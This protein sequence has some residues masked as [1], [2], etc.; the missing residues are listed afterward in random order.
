MNY[1]SKLDRIFSEYIRR[2]DSDPTTGYG[3][4]ISCGKVVHW[5][6]AD[7]GHY[8]NRKHMSLRYDER[9]VHLQC[10]SCNRYD[11]GNMLGYTK[12]LQKKYGERV[13][14][15]LQVKK[16]N[17]SKLGPY[18]FELL[19]KQYQKKLNE[20]KSKNNRLTPGRK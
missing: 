2:R 8:V 11:E 4:C 3:R 17:T 7:A 6:D 19:I 9:N 18:E 1:K 5:K 10:R 13:L 14:D 20:Q 16:N 15:Y 12:A